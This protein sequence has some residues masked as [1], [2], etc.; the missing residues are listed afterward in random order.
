MMRVT[1]KNASV[2]AWSM[3]ALVSLIVVACGAYWH[4]LT[5]VVCASMALV[6]WKS[7]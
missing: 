1:A 5:L 3:M 6:T 7:R 2:A 4:W